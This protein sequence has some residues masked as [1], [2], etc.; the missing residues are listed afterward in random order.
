M[1]LFYSP[2][3][4]SLAVH[5]A[6]LETGLPHELVRVDLEQGTIAADGTPFDAVNPMGKVPALRLA[7]GS[8]LTEAPAILQYLADLAPACG[9]APAAG[10]LARARLQELLNF[11][12]TELHKG[13]APLFDP[14]APQAYKQALVQDAR[15]MLRLRAQL[16]GAGYA[17]GSGFTVADALLYAILRLGRHAGLDFSAW[18]QIGRYMDRVEE[19]STVRQAARLEGLIAA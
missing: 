15:P 19:R 5:I 17:L 9:L 7:D 4:S 2:G 3:A 16:E 8:V 18:P 14:R 13:Y 10:T 11:T 6:L 12:A 1:Q